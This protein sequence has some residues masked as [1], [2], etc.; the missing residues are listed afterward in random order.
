[1]IRR[2]KADVL[3]ELPPKTRTLIPLSGPEFAKAADAERDAWLR[4]VPAMSDTVLEAT[5]AEALGDAFAFDQALERLERDMAGVGVSAVQVAGERQALA[6]AKIPLI[7]EHVRELLANDERRKVVVMAHHRSVLSALASEFGAEA[8]SLHGGTDMRDR[9]GI[10]D[11]FQTNARVRV[12]IT[13][14]DG[15]QT[16]DTVG[17]DEN[18]IEASWQ[19]LLDGIEYYYNNFAANGEAK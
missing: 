10:V 8:V 18:I 15:E 12:F 17:V 1:M 13:T 7:I 6:L 5:L 9:Q 14:S 19:A 16:W 11:T 2:L 3:A 4:L